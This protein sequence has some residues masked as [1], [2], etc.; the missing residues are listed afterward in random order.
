MIHAD[1]DEDSMTEFIKLSEYLRETKTSQ[2]SFATRI[3]KT[4]GAVSHM[5]GRDCRVEREG[6]RLRLIEIVSIA[7]FDDDIVDSSN[8]ASQN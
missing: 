2:A 1:R 8:A 6:G 4:Q 5:L 3:G 7:E